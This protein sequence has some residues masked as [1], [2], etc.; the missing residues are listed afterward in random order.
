MSRIR[1]KFFNE[2]S[3]CRGGPKNA[4]EKYS[5]PADSYQAWLEREEQVDA[6][7]EE[8]LMRAELAGLDLVY[9]AMEEVDEDPPCECVYLDADRADASAC[10]VHGR[11]Q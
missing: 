10:P 7:R 5:M 3:K 6:R 2:F 8:A 9:E 4:L 11:N 1:K